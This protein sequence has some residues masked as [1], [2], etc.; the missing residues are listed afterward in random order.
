MKKNLEGQY[1]PYRKD[2]FQSNKINRLA[3]MNH[4]IPGHMQTPMQSGM[5]YPW[6]QRPMNDPWNMDRWNA[7]MWNTD[8]WSPDMDDMDEQR[9]TEYWQQ[10]YP[11]Q[12]KRIQ[13]EVAHQC[14]L[15]DYEG[16][17]MY[18]E[19]PDRISLSRI[20]ESVYQALMQ[21][22]VLGNVSQNPLSE[23]EEDSDTDGLTPE[24]EAASAGNY[25]PIDQVNMMQQNRRSR[26]DGN[27]R[28]DRSLQDLIEVLL[29]Q[30]MMRRRRQRRRRGRGWYFG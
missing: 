28:N 29:Y 9:D 30:E 27:H 7:D 4:L 23:F 15:L 2:M 5:P 10:M 8:M 22:G 21:H 11:A 3:S 1:R 26:N 19:Y 20:C 17:V 24:E 12:T 14:D 13:R 25:L 6:M 18:D 16:S